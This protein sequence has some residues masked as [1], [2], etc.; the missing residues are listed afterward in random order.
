MISKRGNPDQYLQRVGGTYYARVR[1]PRTLEKYVGQTHIRRSLQT[2]EKAEA[3]RRKHA[4]VASIKGELEA[5]RKTPGKAQ[6]RGISFTEAKQWRDELRA[7]EQSDQESNDEESYL[8]GTILDHLI[9][10]SAEIE[11]LYGAAKAA[12]WVKAATTDETVSETLSVLMDAWLSVSDYKASTNAGHKKALA[13]VLAFLKDDEAIPADVT[14]QKA[15]TFI[16]DDLTQRTPPL[17]YNTIRDRLISLGG[18][19]KWLASR[20]AVPAG[21]NPWTGHKISKQANKGR[22]PEKRSYTDAELTK[23]LLGNEVVKAWPTYAYLPDLMV[24]GLF[25]GARLESLCA[26]R[27]GFVEFGKGTATITIT[28]DKNVSGDRPVGFH[29][30]APLAVLK[31]RTEGK[32]ESELIFPELKTGGLDEKFSASATKAFGR[33]RRACGVPDGTD[34]HSFRRNVMTV[35]EDAGVSQ[36]SIARFVGHKVGTM[37]ADVYVKGG[38]KA[39]ALKTAKEIRFSPEIEAKALALAA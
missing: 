9:D 27:V 23:L 22:S 28:N 33:Y 25:S 3:N 6:E 18:F 31:R 19:W 13:E 7:A 35:L 21:V 20:E 5:L 38:R 24:L 15:M 12:R 34:F 16:D 14:R 29:H 1:V 32:Q 26:L 36:V 2:G 17:S 10:R 11:R 39:I 8:K 30:P 37:A 4:V